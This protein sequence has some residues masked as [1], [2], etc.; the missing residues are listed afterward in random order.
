MFDSLWAFVFA[1]A[2]ALEAQREHVE[3]LERRVTELEG[4][5]RFETNASFEAGHVLRVPNFAP[6]GFTLYERDGT[7]RVYLFEDSRRRFA[8]AGVDEGTPGGDE[9]TR[10]VMRREEGADRMHTRARVVTVERV[11]K[12]TPEREEDRPEEA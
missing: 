3:R 1:L 5:F 9:G 2:S 8:V 10:V 12:E 6:L 7:P 4:G 11:T